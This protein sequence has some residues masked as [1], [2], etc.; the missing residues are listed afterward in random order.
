ME[1]KNVQM[2]DQVGK[3]IS[4]K[5]WIS[6]KQKMNNY[7][8]KIEFIGAAELLDDSQTNWKCQDDDDVLSSLSF[9]LLYPVLSDTCESS[10]HIN[11][12]KIGLSHLPEFMILSDHI[13]GIFLVSVDNLF[14]SI[15]V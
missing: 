5:N 2:E 15:Q 11:K 14:V 4:D 7:C 8:G 3:N 10:R 9:L 1:R 6:Q 12:F 13:H